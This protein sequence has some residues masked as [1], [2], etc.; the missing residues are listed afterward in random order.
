[1]SAPMG[2][3]M[4]RSRTLSESITSPGFSTFRVRSLQTSATVCVYRRS[5][6]RWRPI[7]VGIF[8]ILRLALPINVSPSR[9]LTSHSPEILTSV[10][11]RAILANPSR[12][13]TRNREDYVHQYM[14]AVDDLIKQR[15]I[16]QEDA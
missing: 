16:L 5:P 8:V 13:A 7:R 6:F 4:H 15:W 1:M 14:S 12:N 9:R 2:K 11:G 3:R 10:R